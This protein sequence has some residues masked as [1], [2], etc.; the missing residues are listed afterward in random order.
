MDARWPDFLIIGAAKSG[1]TALFHYL[2]QHPDV[3]ASPVREP[4]FFALGEKKAVFNGPGDEE[5]VNRNS[6]SD[7]NRYRQLF[8]GASEGQIAGEASPFY[9]YHESAPSRIYGAAPQAKL[10]AILRNPVER[11]YAS[12][13]HL[14]RDGRERCERFEEAL[15]LEND[16]IAANWEHLWHFT[17]MGF[18]AQQ[19]KRYLMFFDRQQLHV[20]FYDD[21][22]TDPLASVR[23]CFRFLSLPE[24]FTPDMRRRPNRSGVPRIA[25]IQRGLSLQGRIKKTISSILPER[26]KG[27]TATLVQRWNLRRPPLEQAVRERLIALYRDDVLA[28]AELLDRDLNDWLDG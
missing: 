9:L 4:N 27:S 26:I 13:L 7:R 8:A 21:F 23:S 12:Y 22:K 5:T 3:Y 16:R 14:V 20:V 28:L 19:L 10:I 24:D 25:W 6:V 15:T 17:R 11:A 1:T 18:Y 2:S